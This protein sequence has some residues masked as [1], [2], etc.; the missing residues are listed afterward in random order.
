MNAEYKKNDY[1]W[2]GNEICKV[3]KIYGCDE[4]FLRAVL[5][6]GASV[7]F[8]ASAHEIRIASEDEV[9]AYLG[10]EEDDLS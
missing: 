8:I 10:N 7:P 1:V 5:I 3:D 4:Y 2:F 9:Q 6:E